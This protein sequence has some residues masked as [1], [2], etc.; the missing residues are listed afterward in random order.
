[1]KTVIF[2]GA[3]DPPHIEHSQIAR[4]AVRALGANRLVVVPTYCPPHKSGG[5]LTF[6]DRIRLAQIA[7]EGCADTIVVDTIEYDRTLLGY[8]CNYTSD[9]LPFLKA[10][11][12]DIVY[13]IGGDSFEHFD[14]WYLP[15]EIVKVCPIAVVGRSGYDR[16]ED[17][18]ACVKEKIGGEFIKIDYVGGETASSS[19]K[20]QLLLGKKPVSISDEIYNYITSHRLAEK[21]GTMIEKL[22][23]YQSPDLFNHTENVVMRA[24]HLNSMHNLK[25]PF[26]KVFLGALLHDNAK[27]RQDLDNLNVPIDS[28][29]TPVL[30]QFLGAEK[31]KRDF[32]IDDEDILAAI[33]VHTT[34][35]ADMTTLQKLIYTADSTSYDREYAPIPE[36][37]EIGNENFD[38]GFLAVLDFTYS[39]LLKKGNPIYPLTLEAA[40]YYLNKIADIRPK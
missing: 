31:A 29:G 34:A 8:E 6:D 35:S 25:Q 15:E 12:G 5:F 21:Y 1:M 30:H 20:A 24:V 38:K 3:F 14:T 16:V 28:I 32:A 10:K 26:E 13:L 4:E 33:R 23:G 18:I 2:G 39:K 27:E 40:R 17:R 9:V 11:Y 7:F 22:K 36:L 37:R 19:I